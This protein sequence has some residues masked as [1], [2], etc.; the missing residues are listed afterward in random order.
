MKKNKFFKVDRFSVLQPAKRPDP[1]E[2][3]K[4]RQIMKRM[5]ESFEIEKADLKTNPMVSPKA[6]KAYYDHYK[7]ISKVN[8][9]NDYYKISGMQ[10][11]Y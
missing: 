7:K 6:V 5:E 1:K 8:Q 11:I 10:F 2:E 9:Q 3:E 4:E